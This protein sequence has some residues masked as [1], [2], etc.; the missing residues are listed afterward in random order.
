MKYQNTFTGSKA[1]FAEFIKKTIPDLF[2]SRLVVEG[3][4]IAIPNDAELDYKI[5][6][7]ED[8]FGG[9]VTLKVS[10]DT[11]V[12]EEEEDEVEVDTD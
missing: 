5:K 8:E 10:W 3:K 2:G 4:Q 1:E 9:S 11:G 6:H 7:D 12:E